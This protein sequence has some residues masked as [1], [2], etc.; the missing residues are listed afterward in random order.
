MKGIVLAGGEGT[1]LY[2]LTKVTNKHLLPVYNKPM[3]Y[4]PLNT[5]INSGIKDIHIVSGKGHAGHMLELL[6]DGNE[7]N[8]NLS[9]SIQEQ[10]KGIAHALSLAKKFVENDNMV[11]IL[12]DNIFEDI[13][14]FDNFIKGGRIYLKKV[15]NASRFG[16][17]YLNEKN[18]ITEIIEKPK[19]NIDTLAYAVT[20]LYLYDNKVFDIIDSLKPSD[21]G[22]FE[23]TDVNNLYIKQKKMS[24]EIIKG[25]WSDAGTFESLQ[26][27]SFYMRNICKT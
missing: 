3:I 27:S 1:R 10:S 18:D 7:F 5:L 12:G 26:E 13:F 17:A 8:V 24:Y 14:K 16:C 9:Y 19:R 20:G 4:Y 22:E 11:V 23:I 2:P 21:R 6:G 25:F 15:K